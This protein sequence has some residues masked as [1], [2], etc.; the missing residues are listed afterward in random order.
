MALIRVDDRPLID[1]IREVEL[2]I[3][4]AAG[5]RNLAGSY[6]YLSAETVLLPSRH[7]SGE[8]TRALFV[9][10]E[11]LSVLECECGCEGCWSLSVR[12]TVT[13]D[14]VIWSDFQQPHRDNWAYP[15]TLRLV[16]DRGPYEQALAAAG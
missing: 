2:P 1:I 16:F 8:A 13:E 11:K 14:E 12:I 10:G 5:E 7:L 6:G 15:E 4:D 3:A 9:Y